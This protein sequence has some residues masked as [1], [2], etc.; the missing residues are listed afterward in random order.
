MTNTTQTPAQVDTRLAR[1]YFEIASAETAAEQ[2]E[3]TLDR[4]AKVQGTYEADYPWNSYEKQE[5]ASAV[6]R[7]SAATIKRLRDEAAPLEARYAAER[8]TRFYLVTNTGGHVHWTT[9]CGTC[10]PTTQF[11]WLTEQS[12]MTHEALVEMAGEQACTVCFPDA[13]VDTLRRKSQLE[14]PE[15]KAKRAEKEAK[16]AEK[17]AAEVAVEGYVGYRGRTSTKVFKTV[18][19]ATNDIASHL[20]SLCWYGEGHPSAQEWLTNV[21]QTRKALAAKGVEYDYDKALAAAQK[22]VKREGGTPKF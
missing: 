8:W 12:G 22:K 11:A 10:F 14:T 3:K 20:A 21:E 17:A 2:A 6:L 7:T 9:A 1:I 19:G 13:P 15:A 16:R 5:E 18:R 4:I